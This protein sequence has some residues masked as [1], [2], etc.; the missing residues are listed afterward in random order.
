M[1]DVKFGRKFCETNL[2]DVERIDIVEYFMMTCQEA[3]MFSFMF[4]LLK[5]NIL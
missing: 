2:G 1:D 3:V 4:I 5:F